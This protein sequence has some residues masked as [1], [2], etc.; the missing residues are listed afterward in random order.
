M[1]FADLFLRKPKTSYAMPAAGLDVEKA[2]YIAGLVA[3]LV[4]R[5]AAAHGLRGA[6]PSRRLKVVRMVYV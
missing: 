2:A 5:A 1:A 6:V 4:N 3:N